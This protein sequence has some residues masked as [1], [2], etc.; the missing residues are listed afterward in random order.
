MRQQRQH[1]KKKGEDNMQ[2]RTRQRIKAEAAPAVVYPVHVHQLHPATGNCLWCGRS[3]R[4]LAP[5]GVRVR[6]LW[7]ADQGRRAAA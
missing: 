5:V 7:L 6:Y 1:Q 3:G 2:T 4:D